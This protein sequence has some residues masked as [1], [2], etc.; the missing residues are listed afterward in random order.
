MLDS[1]RYDDGIS[2]N[3]KEFNIIAFLVSS[4][5]FGLELLRMHNSMC[6]QGFYR[7]AKQVFSSTIS[8]EHTANLIAESLIRSTTRSLQIA[9][10]LISK[11]N[12]CITHHVLSNPRIPS[13]S[14]LHFFEF[15][16]TNQ[17]ITPQKPDLESHIVIVL[18]LF[19]AKK[20][21]E[22]KNILSAAVA[23]ENLRCPFSEVASLVSE[24]CA[25]PTVK[26][27]FFDMLFRVYADNGKF[28]E[29]LEV[30]EYMVNN[31]FEIDERSCM[32]YLVA[33][34][35]CNRFG[36]LYDFFQKMVECNVVITVY[37]M[38]LVMDGLCKRKE[39][40]KARKLMHDLVGRGVKPNAYTFNTL[41]DA[42]VKKSNHEGVKDILASMEKA[43]VKFNVATYTLR[44]NWQ[45]KYF[46][47]K[48]AVKVF[49][50]MSAKGVEADIRVYTLMIS[51]YCKKGDIKTAFALFDELVEK[52]VE[53]NAHTYNSLIYGVCKMGNVDA[54]KVLLIE[55]QRKG[56]NL[57]RVIFN[58][59]MDGYCKQ[60]MIDEVLKL[61]AIMEK[62]GFDPDV[63]VYTMI[64][65]C[66]CKLNRHEEAKRELFSMVE[67]GVAPNVYSYTTLIDIYSKEGNLV[68]ATRT[69][70]EME[71]NGEKPSIV[72]Y[73][74]LIHGYCRNGKM[75]EANQLRRK[76]EV[77][78]LL[79]DSY[80]YTSLVQG[81][82]IAGDIDVALK[83][84]REMQTKN[85]TPDMI[86]YTLVLWAASMLLKLSLEISDERSLQ[87]KTA[88]DLIDITRWQY[89]PGMS[90]MP[91]RGE[92]VHHIPSEATPYQAQTTKGDARLLQIA[93]PEKPQSYILEP[94]TGSRLLMYSK[95][96]GCRRPTPCPEPCC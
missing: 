31:K 94:I 55:M 67:K 71:K 66:L 45:A 68:E 70:H 35:K 96:R 28:D 19:G 88:L 52:G 60:G 92:S 40:E 78:G 63:Y 33:L 9:E 4:C 36:S 89:E 3:V 79:L 25:E 48:N 57:N 58:T 32:V 56:I 83:L 13:S 22:A 74:A 69:L 50:E 77:K 46:G 27:K 38:T 30:F 24:S 91:W 16:R 43:G 29:G 65:N 39:V 37:S 87:R 82:C 73:N 23:D 5:C 64:A 15:L 75:K 62:K 26:I 81:E 54:A 2:F 11:V 47:I 17:S 8:N 59:L 53:P 61:Q 80:T 85:I 1:S 86:P 49:E 90:C 84:F 76:L 18:R 6:K 72:T 21:A 42:Y 95:H 41:I 20:F 51:L 7:T 93:W 34:K 12:P 14:C 10:S 44:I